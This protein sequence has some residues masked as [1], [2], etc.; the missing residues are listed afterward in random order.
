MRPLRKGV[1]WLATRQ[2]DGAWPL[3]YPNK[4]RDPQ[5]DVGK[6]MRDAATGFAALALAEL[7]GP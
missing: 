1:V 4:R 7:T 3:N 2:T 5:T 6:F